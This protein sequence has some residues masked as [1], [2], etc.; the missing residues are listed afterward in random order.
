MLDELTTAGEVYWVGDGPIGESDGWV[1]WYVAD[2]EPRRPRSSR[3]TTAAR[4]CWPP[5][6]AAARTSSTRCCP[7]GRRRP[8]APQ[9]VAALWDLVWAG[10]V[11]GDTFA[12]VRALVAGG[13]HRRPA[14]PTAAPTGPGSPAAAW[15]ARPGSPG[16]LPDHGRAAGLWSTRQSLDAGRAAG[17]GRLRPARPLRRGHPGQRADR[18][19]RGRLRRG[20]PGAEHTGGVRPVPPRLLRRR[21][22]RRPVRASPA[23]STGCAPSSGSPSSPQAAGAGRL[24][25]GQPVR[26][27]AALAGAGGPPARPQGRAPW[28]CWST[29]R[30]CST[31]SAAARPC[32]PSPRTPSRLAPAADALARSVRQGQLGKLTVERADGGH[33]FGSAR[34]QRRAAGGRLPDDPAGSAAASGP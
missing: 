7:R 27:R 6:A 15:A 11:T 4:S 31:S 5:W 8:T 1:R 28:S 2:Q 23:P 29:G 19:L 10:L 30:W 26:C 33:V 16:S 32:C 13:A 18:E 14:R 12:P 20:L 34:G 3:P 22:G 17:R 21:S 9:Y 25:P 24:R